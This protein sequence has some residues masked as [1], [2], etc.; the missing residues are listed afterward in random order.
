MFEIPLSFLVMNWV[1]MKGMWTE[2]TALLRFYENREN[3]RFKLSNISN[4]SVL[5]R[6]VNTKFISLN[7]K[8]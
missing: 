2:I 4:E 6:N 5:T 3:I 1:K 8:G 7:I